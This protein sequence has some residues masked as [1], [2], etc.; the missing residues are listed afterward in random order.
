MRKPIARTLPTRLTWAERGRLEKHMTKSGSNAKKQRIRAH[1][2]HTGLTYRE[3]ARTMDSADL[4][5]EARIAKMREWAHRPEALADER[6][7]YLRHLFEEGDH[8]PEYVKACLYV[9]LDRLGT[10]KYID[11]CGVQCTLNDLVAATGLAIRTVEEG[12]NVAR[13]HGWV[14]FTAAH[15][16]ELRVPSEQIGMYE[17]FLSKVSDPVRDRSAYHW[18]QERIARSRHNTEE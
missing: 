4:E 13:A 9:L 16:Y 8:L 5:R 7:W 11:P 6:G 14:H 3:A 1:A 10:G 2:H 18:L 15:E 17:S 12:L